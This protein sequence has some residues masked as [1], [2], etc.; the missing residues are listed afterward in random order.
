M[1]ENVRWNDRPFDNFIFYYKVKPANFLDSRSK[2][3]IAFII[4]Q[5][6]LH[7]FVIRSDNRPIYTSVSGGWIQES[8]GGS[9]PVP[10]RPRM[11]SPRW[12][13]LAR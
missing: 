2:V 1:L 13:R 10:G 6:A 4:F 3:S 7:Q 12:W 9:T 5:R 11:T 8:G